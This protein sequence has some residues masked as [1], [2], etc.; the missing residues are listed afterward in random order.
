MPLSGWVA[1]WVCRFPILKWKKAACK[2]KSQYLWFCASILI[3][4]LELFLM[5][6]TVLDELAITEG[7]L[8][9]HTKF[10]VKPENASDYCFIYMQ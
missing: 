3:I 5:S 2:K 7:T 8:S 6:P 4:C 10:S 9:D 1:L